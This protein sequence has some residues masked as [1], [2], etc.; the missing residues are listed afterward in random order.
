MTTQRIEEMALLI[1]SKFDCIDDIPTNTT[2]YN[3]EATV[4]F[5]DE[6]ENDDSPIGQI[7]FNC[8][9]VDDRKGTYA[10]DNNTFTLSDDLKKY[11]V[12]EIT[13]ERL[14]ATPDGNSTY[15]CTVIFK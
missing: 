9:S 4:Y 3:P 12:E 2:G 1:K 14:D 10:L 6:D 11:D 5:A 13:F 15:R 8:V 7:D